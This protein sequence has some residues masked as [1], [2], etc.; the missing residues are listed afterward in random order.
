MASSWHQIA[1]KI[2]LQIGH[3]I[4]SVSDRFWDQFWPVWDP[5]GAPW[6]SSGSFEDHFGFILI[7]FDVI[8]GST[9][10]PFLLFGVNLG[11]EW[12]YNGTKHGV[13]SKVDFRGVIPRNWQPFWDACTVEVLN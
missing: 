4:D 7:S 5:F 9:W 3:L 1:S 10:C 8:L 6:V 12:H 11:V 2:N 13:P